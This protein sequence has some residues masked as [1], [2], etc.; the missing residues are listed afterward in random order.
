MCTSISKEGWLHTAKKIMKVHPLLS[1]HFLVNDTYFHVHL[2]WFP[3]FGILQ[4]VRL[5]F[6]VV[7]HDRLGGSHRLMM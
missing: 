7:G 6:C 1:Q 3:W 5:V 2:T 4:L